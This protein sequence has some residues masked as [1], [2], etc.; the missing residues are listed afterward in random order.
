[1]QHISNWANGIVVTVIIATIL[2]MILPNGNNKKYIK[3][4]LSLYVLFAI[5]GPIIEF[6][7]AGKYDFNKIIEEI[8]SKTEYKTF[9]INEVETN[10]NIEK[11]YKQ[12]VEEDILSKLKV[13]GYDT[14]ITAL[15]INF[16]NGEKYGTINEVSIKI[17]KKLE[18]QNIEKIEK[19]KIN[20]SDNEN[21]TITLEEKKE[22][23]KYISSEYQVQMERVNI[24]WRRVYV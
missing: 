11:I 10:S 6:L 23:K 7:G 3:T 14:I 16:E 15:S 9:Q 13:K 8:K 24:L 21:N 1:M 22:I 20:V 17:N 2:E 5:I 19:V 4:I 18:N 12:K